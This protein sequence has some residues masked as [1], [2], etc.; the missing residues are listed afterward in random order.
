MRSVALPIRFAALAGA[1]AIAATACGGGGKIN[2]SAPTTV[3]PADPTTTLDPAAAQ[4][5]AVLQAYHDYVDVYIRALGSS[6][7]DDPGLA[8]HL[9]GAALFHERLDLSGLRSAG[10]VLKVTDVV[11]RPTIVSLEPSRAVIDDCLS[12]VPHYY[13]ATSGAVRGTVPSGAS[14]DP[15]EYVLV[16][17][18]GTWKVSEKARKDAVCHA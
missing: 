17:D 9:T 18:A 7:A 12:G 2:T 10:E 8:E 14:G 1:L 4:R 16:L 6:N 15:S 3:K 5:A 11:S 13:D